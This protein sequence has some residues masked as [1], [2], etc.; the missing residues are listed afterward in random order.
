MGRSQD[1]SSLISASSALKSSV[2]VEPSLRLWDFN[3]E[4]QVFL[5]RF[6]CAECCAVR[7]ENMQVGE[8]MCNTFT[9]CL[10]VCFFV[11]VWFLT[12]QMHV[13]ACIYWTGAFFGIIVWKHGQLHQSRKS[14]VFLPLFA[15]SEAVSNLRMHFIISAYLDEILARF[16][17][18]VKL[19]LTIVEPEFQSWSLFSRL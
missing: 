1:W 7:S 8:W 3:P 17:S 13:H 14:T 19:F 16:R 18:L 4:V 5:M 6:W 2:T 10:F 15:S 11:G 12:A 9:V